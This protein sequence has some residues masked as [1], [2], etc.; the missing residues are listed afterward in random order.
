[1]LADGTTG[2]RRDQLPQRVAC[3]R[4]EPGGRGRDHDLSWSSSPTTSCASSPSIASSTCHPGADVRALLADAFDV[5]DAGA[6]TPEASTRSRSRCATNTG[7][8][9]STPAVSRSRSEARCRAEAVLVD[10]HPAVAGT[11]AAVIETLVVPRLTDAQWQYRTTP[12]RGRAGRQGHGLAAILCSPVSVAATRAAAV[13]RVGCRR[14]RR[15]SAKPRTGM[16][17]RT[18]D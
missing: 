18:L 1:V 7:S 8:G 13:D 11:D 16:V 10:E 6:H 12:G 2:S 4:E 5:R 9:S 17:F 14:R 3:G 15:S